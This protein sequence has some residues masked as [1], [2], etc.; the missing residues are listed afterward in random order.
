M[1]A[2]SMSATIFLPAHQI[3]TI[4]NQYVQ[5]FLHCQGC[6]KVDESEAEGEDIVAGAELE[7]FAY[8]GLSQECQ[9]VLES[10]RIRQISS[11]TRSWDEARLVCDFVLCTPLLILMEE[12][13][14]SPAPPVHLDR[15]VSQVSGV[16][17]LQVLLVVRGLEVVGSLMGRRRMG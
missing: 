15:S 13:I 9:S 14:Y 8:R 11:W 10:S 1:P 3:P 6:I 4:H 5:A 12:S 17:E 16:E 2:S 7:E